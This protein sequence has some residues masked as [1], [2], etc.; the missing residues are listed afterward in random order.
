M[1]Y[2]LMKFRHFSE[3]NRFDREYP[4]YGG[5]SES[6]LVSVRKYRFN[7]TIRTSLAIHFYRVVDALAFEE[8]RLTMSHPTWP[9]FPIYIPNKIRWSDNLRK[10]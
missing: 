4:F 5:R 6:S 9:F 1:I 3:I 10:K 2:A 8:F 7:C